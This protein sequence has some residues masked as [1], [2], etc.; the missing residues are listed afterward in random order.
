MT[1]LFAH[2]QV[3]AM[4]SSHL[5]RTLPHDL[6]QFCNVVVLL[7]GCSQVPVVLRLCL[8]LSAESSLSVRHKKQKKQEENAVSSRQRRRKRFQLLPP[9]RWLT[10]FL[11]FEHL[12]HGRAS[13][14]EWRTCVRAGLFHRSVISLRFSGRSSSWSAWLAS[15]RLWQNGS[16]HTGFALRKQMNTICQQVNSLE[17]NKIKSLFFFNFID[18]C[19]TFTSELFL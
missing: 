6:A 4:L 5:N 1:L 11:R 15:S 17:N 7:N 14:S 12:T 9:W 13:C 10:G 16:S 3:G 18:N 19:Y 2:V 8:R